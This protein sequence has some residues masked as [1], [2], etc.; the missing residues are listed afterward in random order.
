ME[1][2]RRVEQIGNIAVGC[3]RKLGGMGHE[4][5]F[6]HVEKRLLVAIIVEGFNTQMLRQAEHED[7]GQ[8]DWN[9][10]RGIKTGKGLDHIAEKNGIGLL[11]PKRLV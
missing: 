6:F 7:D 2:L 5:A 8:L 10:L 9:P 3:H 4:T 11:L 1:T